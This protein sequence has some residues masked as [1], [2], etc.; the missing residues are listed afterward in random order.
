MSEAQAITRIAPTPSGYLHEGNA[1]NFLLVRRLADALNARVLLRI[2]DMDADRMRPEYVEDVFDV[3]AWLGVRWEA[4]P[5][6]AADFDSRFSLRARR[7]SYRRQAGTL[8]AAGHAYVCTCS[9]RLGA[10]RCVQGCRAMQHDLVPGFS[11]LRLAIDPGTVMQVD[12]T[13]IDLHH[14]LGDPVLWRRDDHVAYH[15]ASVIEDRD[16]GITHVVRGEDLRVSSALHAHLG[17]LVG[18]RTSVRFK[19]HPLV[20]DAQ[21]IKLSKSQL[22]TGP[23]PRTAAQRARIENI[24]ERLAESIIEDVAGLVDG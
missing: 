18:A 13:D 24:A 16:H 9:R 23:M 4:G 21:G 8:M 20:V 1:V 12:G 3:L 19:H 11:A 17:P 15:L 5:I 2:D 14:E 6:D 7:E 22:R 10:G